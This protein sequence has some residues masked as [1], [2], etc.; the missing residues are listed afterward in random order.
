MEVFDLVIIGGGING[1][2]CAADASLRGLNVLLC[3]QDDLASKTSSSST[4]LIHG[5]LR[6][7]ELWDFNL[8][9]KALDE[10]QILLEVAP[11]LVFPITLLIP[12]VKTMRSRFLIRVGLFIYDHLSG[13]NKLPK[14]KLLSRKNTPHCFEPLEVS[15]KKGFQYYDAVTDDARLTITNALQAK[16]HGAQILTQTKL[17]KSEVINGLWHLTLQNKQ[18]KCYQVQSKAIIN[19]TGAWIEAVNKLMNI[20]LAHKLTLVKGSHIVTHKLYEGDQA[21]LLQHADNRIV[22]VIPYNGYTLIGTTDVAFSGTLDDLSIEPEET[23]YLCSIV[24]RYFHKQLHKNDIVHKF[25]G[26]RPLVGTPNR[27][28][29]NISREYVFHYSS[30]PAPAITI[31]SGKITTYRQL[32]EKVIDALLPAFPHLSK[33]C[34]DKVLLPGARNIKMNFEEFI[35]FANE[36]YYWLEEETLTR[37]IKTY[38]TRI[39]VLLLDKHSMNDL[40]IHFAPTLYQAEVDFL[41]KEE[42]ATCAE[43]ILWRRTKL[44]LGL[45]YSIQQELSKYIKQRI[46]AYPVDTPY[47][48]ENQSA[49][50]ATIS[51]S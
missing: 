27:Q 17:I 34:T 11:H 32:S 6:Y 51:S 3:E 9:K 24:N 44:G 8:V 23:H 31:Y 49:A 22:F 1:C 46:K 10:R 12:Y 14:S 36:K 50:T 2:G 37:Y 18:G 30:T 45:D 39:E 43:D 28:L 48:D 40:G 21:Y 42:W 19:A 35:H 5:G 15:I 26:V 41:I 13:R 4:K 29:K 47:L 33:S 25:S 7:L 20:P 16:E 38:G